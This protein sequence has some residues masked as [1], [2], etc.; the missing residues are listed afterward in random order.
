[1]IQQPTANNLAI[2]TGVDPLKGL[3]VR[4]FGRQAPAWLQ[5]PPWAPSGPQNSLNIEEIH[6][7]AFEKRLQDLPHTPQGQSAKD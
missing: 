7:W 3:G 6:A 2:H 5:R 4:L 1:M